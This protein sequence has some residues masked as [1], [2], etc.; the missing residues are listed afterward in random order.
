MAIFA[1]PQDLMTLTDSQRS[2]LSIL[3]LAQYAP[4][5]DELSPGSTADGFYV[6]YHH[7]LFHA[8]RDL[9]LQV[10]PCR[11]LDEFLRIA[12][13]YDYVF[14]VCNRFWM[15]ETRNSMIFC[16]SVCDYLRVP[17]LGAP[18]NIRALAE[19]KYL[20]KGMAA[21]AG[22]PVLPGKVFHDLDDLDQAPTFD[23]P[24]F[25][26]PRFGAASEHV[27]TD[28]LQDSWRG[29]RERVE[30]LLDLGLEALVERGI[31]GTDIT[32]PVVG[33][34]L[35]LF[36][37]AIARPSGLEH[38]ITTHEQ[39]IF[40]SRPQEI[41]EQ[42]PLQEEIADHV[43]RLS[44]AARPFDYFRVDLRRDDSTGETFLLEF[45]V[46]CVLDE[47][48]EFGVAA[49]RLGFSFSALLEHIVAYSIARQDG[50]RR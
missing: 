46:A 3:F 13:Q 20:T 28:S 42:G 25:I 50:H 32:V 2:G 45:N 1:R 48:R 24:Y 16:S 36:F 40:S 41:L 9:G 30:M 4:L 49:R 22:I 23:G 6:G 35:P 26:K 33:G 21:H 14:T 11:D 43:S 15:R 19:D 29:A 8:L 7:R 27:T 17:Y 39:K 37:P 34:K 10:T 38:G 44:E 5:A 12:D 18:P 31:T 47:G